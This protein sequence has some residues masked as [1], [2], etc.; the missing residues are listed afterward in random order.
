[1]LSVILTDFEKINE[2][3]I[4]SYDDVRGTGNFHPGPSRD[5]QMGSI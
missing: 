1:M 3:S 5:Q 2:V 4:N